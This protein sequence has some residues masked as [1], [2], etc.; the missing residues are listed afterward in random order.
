M[1]IVRSPVA[2]A[3]IKSIDFSK[4][5]SDPNFIATLTGEDLLKVGVTP[6]TQNQWPPQKRAER[7]HLA[8]GKVRFAGEAVAAVLSRDKYAIE[9]LIERVKVNYDPLPVITTIQESKSEKALVYED[10]NNNI[11]QQDETKW[12]DA[13]KAISSA[14]YAINA[15]ENIERQAAA[16]IEPRAVFVEY[17]KGN[18]TFEVQSTVQSAHGL[19]HLLSTELKLPPEKFHVTVQ[20]VGGGFGSKGAQS[21]PEALL[22]CLFAKKTGLPI[23]WTATRTDEFLEAASGRDE[24]L[25]ITLACGKDGK[26]IALK[27]KLECNAGVSGTQNHMSMMTIWTMIGLYGIRNVD[28]KMVTYVTNKMPL[29]PVRGA[30]VPEGVYFIERAI[31]MLARKSGIDPIEFRRRN[32]SKSASKSISA[33]MDSLIEASHYTDLIRWRNEINSKPK[34]GSAPQILAGIGVSVH[35]GGSDEEDSTQSWNNQSNAE[36]SGEKADSNWNESDEEN[37]NSDEEEGGVAGFMTE[38]AKVSIDRSGKVTV[39]T[40]SSPHGQGHETTFAQLASEELGVPIENI[41]I[42][43][44]DTRLIPVA[45][46]TFG[47]RSAATGGSAV[48]DASRKLKSLLISRAAEAPGRSEESLNISGGYVVSS[49][50]LSERLLPIGD[51]LARSSLD[52]LSADSTFTLKEMSHSNGVHLC[53]LTLDVQQQKTS[54]VKYV[55]VE[56]PGRI[57]NRAIVE[58]QLEGGVVHAIGGALHERL[59][60]DHDGNLL[61]STFLDYNIPAAQESPDIEIKL[62]GTPTRAVLDGAKGIGESGTI[63]GYAAVVN[64]VNDALS[65]ITESK[66]VNSAPV[67]QEKIYRAIQ[68]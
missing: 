61:T 9:D 23:K 32:L 38:T 44:G 59:V 6:I 28:L 16:P 45:T 52:E 13:E 43:W 20:D 21:Y 26:L 11:S 56:D 37:D 67:T 46:G 29:G 62:I 4:I 54:I 39:F 1:G 53:A 33:L 49:R 12:G 31:D 64:A 63:A 42:R 66:D 15:D 50:D 34:T 22:A 36:T 14:A 68:S 30:G 27:G 51:V 19:R 60:H 2:H 55:V 48:V 8:V 18:D 47:S 35:G 58:G 17:E 40:G 25:N 10:W 24:Y 57:I 5:E 3:K 65:Q 7:Y 41:S